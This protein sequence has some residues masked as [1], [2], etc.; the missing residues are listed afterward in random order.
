MLI[1]L[2]REVRGELGRRG[3][4]A[5]IRT[6]R[7]PRGRRR[8]GLPKPSHRDLVQWSAAPRKSFVTRE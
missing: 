2:P 4:P 1:H 5:V 3:L 6:H 7:R 8:R